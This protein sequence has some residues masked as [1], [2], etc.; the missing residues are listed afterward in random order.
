MPGG[1]P[2]PFNEE[3]K[4]FISS[5]YNNYTGAQLA[6]TLNKLRGVNGPHI[7]AVHVL[8][9]I[10]KHLGGKGKNSRRAVRRKQETLQ[11]LQLEE[12]RVMKGNGSRPISDEDKATALRRFSEALADDLSNDFWADVFDYKQE[13]E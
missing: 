5:N 13:F 8:H 4:K 3:E 9:Y 10:W 12:H 1:V 11:A 7:K 2:C 6:E